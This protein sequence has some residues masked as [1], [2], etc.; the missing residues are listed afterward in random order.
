MYSLVLHR[1]QYSLLSSIRL[2]HTYWLP[3]WPLKALTI[4]V[5]K[6][7]TN[8]LNPC[9]PV[10]QWDMAGLKITARAVQP[11]W[12]IFLQIYH[13]QNLDSYDDEYEKGAAAKSSG[14]IHYPPE[15]KLFTCITMHFTYSYQAS[16]SISSDT[17]VSSKR[18]SGS[19]HHAHIKQQR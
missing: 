13:A 10:L 5:L 15:G 16:S 17:R 18:F 12:G 2:F 8:L 14:L 1:L 6:E 3:V 7:D 11:F 4:T 19:R 9:K